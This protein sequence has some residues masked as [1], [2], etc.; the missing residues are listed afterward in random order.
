[1]LQLGRLV[2]SLPL[3]PSF[4]GQDAQPSPGLSRRWQG[5]HGAPDIVTPAS[6][7]QGLGV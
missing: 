1:M 5:Q 3:S 6:F 4:P 2:S 7:P